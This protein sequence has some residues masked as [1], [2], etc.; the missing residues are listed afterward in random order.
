MPREQRPS[1]IGDAL[2]W[3]ARIIAIGLAMFL[4]AVAGGWID[5]RAGTTWCGPAGLVLGF[6]AGMAW[7]WQLR[8]RRRTG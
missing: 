4:P 5:A 7:L 3:A 8:K 1:P 2:V 6:V